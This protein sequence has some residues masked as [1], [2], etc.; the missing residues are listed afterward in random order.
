MI[1]PLVL[2]MDL[3]YVT[4]SWNPNLKCQ[5]WDSEFSLQL[6]GHNDFTINYGPHQQ[7][8]AQ[9]GDFSDFVLFQW[10]NM[11]HVD[12]LAAP[13]RQNYLPGVRKEN[14]LAL[15]NSP[16]RLLSS[17]W[18]MKIWKESKVLH[19]E[20]PWLNEVAIVLPPHFIKSF[21]CSSFAMSS[22]FLCD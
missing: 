1:F 10:C 6:P 2:G 19:W 12:L 14:F 21:R 13:F 16:Y 8:P 5:E 15:M 11:L 7:P 20:Y 22:C 4:I 9:T 18:P 3:G 17:K